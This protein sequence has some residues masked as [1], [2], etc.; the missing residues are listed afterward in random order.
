MA[1][2]VAGQGGV[3]GGDCGSGSESSW[4]TTT[5]SNSKHEDICTRTS[6]ADARTALVH[7]NKGRATGSHAALWLRTKLQY[8]LLHLGL[9][10]SKHA[11]KVIFVACLVLATFCV[12]LKTA[13]I[14]TDVERLWVEEGGRLEKELAYVESTLGPGSGNTK[15]I[16]I[17]T[18]KDEGASI[19]NPQALLA[20]LNVLRQATQVKIDM[21]DISW[22]LHDIC[23]APDFP[24]FDNYMLQDIFEKLSPCSIITPLDC[25]WEGSKLLGPEYGL[26]IPGQGSGIRWSNLHPQRVLDKMQ[27]TFM[28]QHTGGFDFSAFADFMKRAGIT[29]G[30]LEKPCLDPTDTECPL[31]APN[32]LSQQPPNVGAELTGG[33]YGFAA[34]FMHWP[35]D[36]IVGAAQTNKTGHI[37]RAEALQSIVELMG[38]KY[39]YE[40]WHDNYR[41][42]NIDWSQEKAGKIL[43]AWQ[44]KFTQEVLKQ[45]ALQHNETRYF[46]VLPFSSATLTDLLRDFSEVPIFRVIIGYVFMVLYSMISLARL[47]DSVRSGAGLGLAGV[48][49]VSVSVAAGLGFCALLNLP[50]NASTTQV[51]PFLALGLGV[52]D[53]FLLAYTFADTADNINIPYHER[54]GEVV[55]RAGVSVVL[56]SVCNAC[57]F[58][59]GALVPVPALRAFCLQAALLVLV[60]LVATLTVFPAIMSLDLRRRNHQQMDIFCCFPGNFSDHFITIQ[61]TKAPSQTL[62]IHQHVPHCEEG[63]PRLQ[64]HQ[65]SSSPQS[66]REHAKKKVVTRALPLPGSGTVTQVVH[67]GHLPQTQDCWGQ[68]PPPQQPTP[69]LESIASAASSRDLLDR[70]DSSVNN[71]YIGCG[72]IL[73][74]V[75]SWCVSIWSSWSVG[76]LCKEVYGPFLMRGPVKVLTV[77]ALFASIGAAVWGVSHVKDGLDLTDIVPRDTPE[78]GFLS[79]QQKYFGF[80]NMFAVTQGNFEY[81]VK[82][83]LLHEYHEAFTRVHHII[84]NDDGGLPE[85]WLSLFRDWLI[86]LQNS[87]DKDWRDGCITQE[88]WH[89]NASEEGI[90]GYKLLV[91]TGHVD[92]PIDHSLVTEVRLVNNEGIINP[93]AFYNYLT[94][95]VSN[96]ALAY[97]ASQADLRPEPRPWIHEPFDTELRIPKSQPLIYAQLPFYLHNLADTA[98]ITACIEEV[99]TICQR[100]E[101]QGLPNFPKGVPFTFWEQYIKLRFFLVLALLAVHGAVFLVLAIVLMNL[102]AAALVVLLLALLVLQ[103][104]GVLGMLGIKL[105]AVPA[106]LLVLSVGVGVEFCV[107]VTVGFLTSVGGRER[108]VQ[109]ALQHMAAPVLH[110]A[111][112]TLIASVM[113]FFSEF[114]FIRRY[115][116]YVLLALTALGILDGLVFLP[117]LLSLVGPPAEVVPRLHEDRLPT[118]SPPPSPAPMSHSHST[119]GRSSSRRQSSN[120]SSNNRDRMSSSRSSRRNSGG[121][122]SSMYPNLPGMHGSNLSLT[123]ITEEPGSSCSR[124]SS[125]SLRSSHEIV[126]EPEV[127]VET[128]TTPSSSVDGQHQITTKVTATAKVHLELHTPLGGG[129]EPTVRSSGGNVRRSSRHSSSNRNCCNPSSSTHTTNSSSTSAGSGQTNSGS[130][131]SSDAEDDEQNT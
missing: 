58:F 29:S 26:N 124:S 69:S 65:R 37:V 70:S 50:F 128:T 88:K 83:K 45:T 28:G 74:A 111:A 99:R 104:F 84:K 44:H 75:L 6:W 2:A 120:I 105:S 55:K 101:D 126:V 9:F 110:G 115:F 91:Q 14:L 66:D 5:R 109:L 86:G 11:G 57:A 23:Y 121:G 98:T 117:V 96:D 63:R 43:N 130:S 76:L 97:S 13:T 1:I 39:L 34:N 89:R 53:M 4:S 102:W 25:F 41:V 59:A 36:L 12:G 8:Q 33:C 30:Y 90:L 49:L 129:M 73:S 107:H 27:K 94:A 18:P 24:E 80:Y 10:S 92:N 40:Y 48:L 62:P 7:I 31:E 114:D 113:M 52:D 82:Q 60:N 16:L 71:R 68:V 20:H 118:P 131:S 35:A 106:V 122:R 77:F 51:L 67:P 119:S 108:R 61:S 72:A 93:K 32:K 47:T 56:T 81:P 78:F 116:F 22:S 95:W 64:M 54:V 79:A 38:P 123:T 46:N 125:Q 42:H 21:F 19:L 112:S 87:F 17:F 85:F 15:Q 100:Y 3:E 127:V 103:L